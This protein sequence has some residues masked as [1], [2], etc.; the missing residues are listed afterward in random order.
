MLSS[1]VKEQ[2][3]T[4]ID[5]RPILPRT[6]ENIWSRAERELDRI[7]DILAKAAAA[8]KVSPLLLKSQPLAFPLW[9]KIEFWLPAQ[10]TNYTDRS[11]A[12]IVL[13]PKPHHTYEF[14]YTLKYSRD[15]KTR[16]IARIASLDE[17]QLLILI[18]FL[19]RNGEKPNPL[20]FRNHGE[21]SF[22]KPV[23]E[24]GDIGTDY[25]T[26]GAFLLIIAGIILSLIS[27]TA[28]ATPLLGPALLAAGS[29]MLWRA[30]KR[31]LWIRCDGKPDG[32]PRTL[33]RVDSWQTVIFG[34]GEQ[35]SAFQSRFLALLKSPPTDKFRWQ[36]EK[37]WY[38]G[39][40]GKEE[41]EQAVLNFGRG[42]VYCQIYQYGKDL[43]IGWDGHIN[44]GQWVEKSIAKGIDKSTGK[45]TEIRFANPGTQH[46]S[47]YDIIDLSCLMEWTHAQIVHL[48][49]DLMN[50]LKIDQEIDFKILRGERQGLTGERKETV[51]DKLKSTFKR[52]E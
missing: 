21:F 15:G 32:E 4:P 46:I 22:T 48:A 10:G 34:I 31:P 36:V 13:D 35:Q 42:I 52:V 20:T 28:D 3:L 18:Q 39:L 44:Y 50:E 45:P 19:L 40:D 51:K 33:L 7:Y 41:R 37:V 25:L 30:S 24:I 5:A 43:Y 23:N 9:V 14:E 17:Q 8:E 27:L 47:E 2:A 38:W 1:S 16:T 49:K 29:I 11:G 6:K 12:T 26:I